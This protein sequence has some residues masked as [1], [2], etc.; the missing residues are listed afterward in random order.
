[1]SQYFYSTEIYDE[2]INLSQDEAFHAI[3]VLRKKIGDQIHIVDGKGNLFLTEIESEDIQNCQLKI[4]S[5][6]ENFGKKD[7]NV[8][9]AI[10]PPKSHD[11]LELFIEKVVELGVNEISFILTDFSE[12]NNVKLNRIDKCT[13][14]AM[15]QS[16]K[17]Y[18]PKVN[19]IVSFSDFINNCTNKEKYIA[20]LNESKNNHLFQSASRKSDYCILVGPEGGFSDIEISESQKYNFKSVTLSDSRL[21]IETAGIVA[22]SILNMINTI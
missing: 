21:R 13:L 12:R 9:L 15:K 17:T 3:K 2:I 7:Y 6:H 19:D 16:L 8:H 14:S 4:I 5:I 10:A 11:R 1:M 22:C 18:L 20:H